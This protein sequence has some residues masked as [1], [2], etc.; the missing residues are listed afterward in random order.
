MKKLI[1]LLLVLV[2]VAGLVACAGSND[3][4]KGNDTTNTENTADSNGDSN[5]GSGEPIYIGLSAKITG[6]D[7]ANGD[8]M[9]KA[10]QMA[11]DEVNAAGGLLGGRKVELVI[12][13]DATDNA[14]AVNVAN[15]FAGNDKISAVVG[16]WNSGMILAAEGVY[17]DAKIPFFGLGTNP[18]LLELDNEYCFLVRA[19]DN[20]MASCA[21]KLIIDEF[22]VKSV[23]IMYTNNEFGTGA[24]EVIEAACK[25]A[26]MAVYPEAINIGDTDVTGQILDLK[27]KGAECM[28]VW[29]SDAEYVLTAR[30]A[31]ELG[32][33]VPTVASPAITMDQVRDLCEPEWV[34]GWYSVTDFVGNSD[35]PEVTAFCDKYASDYGEGQ[36]AELYVADVYDLGI[37]LALIVCPFYNKPT[38]E[39]LYLHYK[40]IAENTKANIMLY[41]IPIFVG[42]NLEAETVGRLAAIPNIVGVKDE[43]GV[44]PTQVTDFFLATEKVDPNF[45]VYNGDDIMLLPTIVQ[46]AM[47]IVSGGAHIFGH[48]IRAIFEAFEKGENEKAKELF[49]PMYRFCKTTGQNGRILPNSLLRPAIEAVTGIKLGPARLP[50]APATEAELDVTLGVLRELGKL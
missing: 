42:V 25:D 19:N 6:A 7:A 46:G 16:P 20:L 29:A 22:K 13:D 44:N 38:Q 9:V 37:E 34:E 1:A 12:Q 27:S 18:K 47:G 11:V 26:G 3:E 49:V 30:Q 4:T 14:M 23:G 17:K 50:L 39:G 45:V 10:A 32:L 43:A 24:M 2:M 5:T 31:Y 36:K 48:E 8:R 41:N 33:Q 21:A 35:D 28:V 40:T 15:I